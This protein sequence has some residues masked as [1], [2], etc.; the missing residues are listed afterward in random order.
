MV[1]Q[2]YGCV[3]GV[4]VSLTK[5]DVFWVECIHLPTREIS[6]V[7]FW[8][9]NFITMKLPNDVTY[10]WI[11]LYIYT[12]TVSHTYKYVY[13]IYLYIYMCIT[14]VFF[15]KQNIYQLCTVYFHYQYVCY[16]HGDAHF[17]SLTQLDLERPWPWTWIKWLPKSR[18]SL[19][20]L[21]NNISGKQRI[22]KFTKNPRNPV[23]FFFGRLLLCLMFF[24]GGSH[25][26]KKQ[27]S[28]G[29]LL[30]LFLHIFFL[31]IVDVFW[32]FKQWF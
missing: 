3:R 21:G 7:S 14:N 26:Q 25:P 8:G 10:P 5:L 11:Y 12:Y 27:V 15:L 22:H 32:V 24:F 13:I 29:I 31:K 6:K 1:L 20:L 16:Y 28:W 23:F 18:Q 19:V 17:F 30:H 2:W 4:S 9:R